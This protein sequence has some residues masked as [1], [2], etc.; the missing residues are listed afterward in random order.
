MD[1][2]RIARETA[3]GMA[4]DLAAMVATNARMLAQKPAVV[5]Q[6]LVVPIRP[7]VQAELFVPWPMTEADWDQFL[8]VLAAMRPGLVPSVTDRSK[9][10]TEGG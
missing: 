1:A 6:R 9:N 10:T 8:A 3:T 2:E 7:H 5:H 4:E